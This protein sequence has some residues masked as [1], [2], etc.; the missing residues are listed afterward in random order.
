MRE[1][2]DVVDVVNSTSSETQGADC[3]SEGKSKRPGKRMAP[4]KVKDMEKSP[5]GQCFTRPVPNGRSRSGFWLVPENVLVF[6]PIRGQQTLE[7]FRVFLHAK[8]MKF[9]CS[10]CLSWLFTE[11]LYTRWI[12]SVWEQNARKTF[13]ISTIIS[14]VNALDLS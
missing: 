9:S 11:A 8:Y 13:R 14:P 7:S 12:D 4:R 1:I 3:G 5:W 10:P 2:Q 6:L